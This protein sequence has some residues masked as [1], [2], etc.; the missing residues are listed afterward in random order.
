MANYKATIRV[1]QEEGKPGCTVEW[2]SE[3]APY[4][5]GETDAVAA[6]KGV[7]QAGLDNLKK[8]FGG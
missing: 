3:F 2:S 6:I 5:A 8:L 7:Y 4:G 1:Q